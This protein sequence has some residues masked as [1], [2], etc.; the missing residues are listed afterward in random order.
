MHSYLLTNQLALRPFGPAI[1]RRGLTPPD[2]GAADAPLGWRSALPNPPGA[3][4]R[5][6]G[7][8]APL[9]TRGRVVVRHSP[10]T[11]WRLPTGSGHRSALPQD[12]L[13]PEGPLRA[14]LRTF[15]APGPNVP[16]LCPTPSPLGLP[17]GS[18]G[19]SLSTLSPV[20]QA[21]TVRLGTGPGPL[22]SCARLL[23]RTTEGSGR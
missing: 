6:R 20:S 2:P 21:G 8:A 12:P 22:P 1:V 3:F 7:R 11:P 5:T 18:R 16:H 15:P 19:R 10:C 13:L 23:T 17:P 14:R 9:D 4:S